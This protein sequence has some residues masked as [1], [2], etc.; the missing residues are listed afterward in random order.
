MNKREIYKQGF[1]D[2][3]RAYA[4]WKDGTEWVG[5]CGTTLKQA[6]TKADASYNYDYEKTIIYN[7][8]DNLINE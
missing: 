3:L 5:T 8:D 4:W 6:I 2:G 1:I 7:K